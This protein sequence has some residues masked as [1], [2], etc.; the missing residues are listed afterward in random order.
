MGRVYR[1]CMIGFLM[2]VL[3]GCGGR[4]VAPNPA[5]GQPAAPSPQSPDAMGLLPPVA[6][7]SL[8]PDREGSAMLLERYG[9]E[10]EAEFAQRVSDEATSARFYP[11][12]VDGSVTS[13]NLAHAVYSFNVMGFAGV[14]KVKFE[15][16]NAPDDY[17]NLW[18][19]FSNWGNNKWDW[20]PGPT[21]GA[22]D[23]TG[24][25]FE[26]YTRPE[27]G[28]MLVAVVILGTERA[29][30]DKVDIGKG[31]STPTADLNVDLAIVNTTQVVTF[32]ASDSVGSD[33][34]IVLYEFD[35]EG[36]GTWDSSGSS[37]TATHTYDL[38]FTYDAIVR[39]TDNGG[40]RDTATT[41]V[42]VT[43]SPWSMRGHD[44]LHTGRSP[45]V[46]PQADSV[47]WTYFTG[48]QVNSPVIGVDGTVY[49][50]AGGTLY[51]FFPDGSLNWQFPDIFSAREAPAIGSDG[52]VYVDPGN[53][54]LYAIN[55]DGSLKWS[56]TKG[57]RAGSAP[58][59]GFDG[60]VYVGGDLLYAVYPS[61][62]LKWAYPA[63]GLFGS[64]AIGT[65]GTVYVGCNDFS[66]YAFNI[67]GSIKWSF[68]T[69]GIV[70]SSPA[71]GRDGT[72]YVGSKDKSLYAI[73][74][75]GSLKWSYLTDDWIYASPSIGEDG[76]VYVGC[77]NGKLYAVNP[78]GSLKWT[79]TT[80]WHVSSSPCIDAD[81]TI[82]VG[83]NDDK[84][85]A[86]NPDGSLKWSYTTGG[87]VYSSPA[88]GADGTLYVGSGD[89]KLYA[90]HTFNDNF[91]PFAYLASDPYFGDEGVTITLDASGSN[92]TDGNITEYE[93]DF[94][95][96]GQYLSSGASDSFSHTYNS[97]GVYTASVRITDDD[98]AQD[99]ATTE[100]RVN[101]TINLDD[102]WPA[103]GRDNR[104]TGRSPYVGA[105]TNN[106]KWTY[107]TGWSVESSPTIDADG[108]IYVGGRD[109]EIYAV[110][111]DG[112]IKWSYT[113]GDD[114]HST[115]AIGADGTVYAGSTDFKLYA[116]NADGSLKWFY[117]TGDKITSSPVIAPDGTV[118]VGS[119]DNRLIAVNPDGTLKWSYLT[120]D[121]VNS[122]P[123]IAVD[124]TVYVGSSDHNFYAFDPDGSLKWSYDMWDDI[125]SSPAIGADGTTYVGCSFRLFAMNPDGSLKW[126][127]GTGSSTQSSPAIGVDGTIYIGS[128]SHDLFAFNP[129]GSLKWT[130]TTGMDIRS[131]PAIGADGTLYIASHDHK[132]YAIN[133]N[134]SLKWLYTTGEAMSSSPAISA[135]GTVYVGGQDH[136][137]YAFGT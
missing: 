113:T 55:P 88:I 73:N 70:V 27:T 119:R 66:L 94:E 90:F 36:D 125:D 79:Y 15:W 17:A 24:A 115:P 14:E 135:D 122:S 132:F 11:A 61:G 28:D 68:A 40:G 48:S 4:R 19:G 30:L 49:V 18:I 5:L 9:R 57:E 103:R 34:T 39:V 56:F 46:G 86:I 53:E 16:G 128:N 75:D 104:H 23:L 89:E 129:D 130:Y 41:Q 105:Q 87:S 54:F 62:I 3:V 110:N 116:L 51:S 111:P 67:D 97:H 58:V 81:G 21:D 44:T 29:L 102:P 95:G 63:N 8:I 7:L 72:I 37:S 69:E 84:I 1:L 10:Y 107:T 71:I 96:D 108:T 83:S 133:P 124:G 100:V 6:A 35:F 22:I 123:A 126:K 85:Y 25:G 50:G 38:Q 33:G 47:K 137:L 64:P 26:D 31:S 136:K 93:W 78:G 13:D 120:G 12:W 45:F 118:Y 76:T 32:D 20:H 101:E 82:Y 106:V 134:G 77:E 127:S 74:P 98:G 99:T 59:I 80:G 42:V 109:N 60:T 2:I 65:D 117:P 52:T 91:P 114:V 131:S 92:D 121:D 112:T 43:H